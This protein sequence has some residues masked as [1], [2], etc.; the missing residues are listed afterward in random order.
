VVQEEE[1]LKGK[2]ERAKRT[3]EDRDA[4]Y[5]EAL[6]VF[7]AA[8][9]ERQSLVDSHR[10]AETRIHALQDILDNEALQKHVSKRK[11]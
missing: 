8:D 1:A 5:R 2:V 9:G 6:A 11:R 4:T 3:V 10:A 7:R